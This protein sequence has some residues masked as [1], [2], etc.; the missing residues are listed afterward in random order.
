[1][2]RMEDPPL[3][4]VILSKFPVK[5]AITK[6]YPDGHT[7]TLVVHDDKLVEKM[8]TFRWDWDYETVRE[9]KEKRVTVS[10]KYWVKGGLDVGLSYFETYLFGKT[11]ALDFSK[12]TNTNSVAEDWRAEVSND[13]AFPLVDI[14]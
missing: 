12:V 2:V 14:K 7:L 8:M 11:I 1:M 5:K 9:E 4:I 13:I 10:F 3:S 6:R